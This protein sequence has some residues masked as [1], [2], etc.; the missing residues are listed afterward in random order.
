MINSPAGFFR[1]GHFHNNVCINGLVQNVLEDVHDIEKML[2]SITSKFDRAI[3]IISGA[4]LQR[5]DAET[6]RDDLMIPDLM[7]HSKDRLVLPQIFSK[8]HC[9]P[10][11]TDPKCNSNVSP[12]SDIQKCVLQSNPNIQAE[13]HAAFER[14]A[15]T[16]ELFNKSPTYLAEQEEDSRAR[17][18]GLNNPRNDGHGPLGEDGAEVKKEPVQE[19]EGNKKNETI[20]TA[21]MKEHLSWTHKYITVG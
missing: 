20:G 10:R 5:S 6:T 17:C 18:E 14:K 3:T 9:G 13:T 4:K 16:H 11:N 21:V 15:S 2:F 1:G 12:L 8:E 19:D 7:I